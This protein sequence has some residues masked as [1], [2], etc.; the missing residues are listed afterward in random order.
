MVCLSEV[1]KEF[2]PILTFF[3][4]E[5][6]QSLNQLILTPMKSLFPKFIKRFQIFPQKGANIA[7]RFNYAFSSAFKKLNLDSVLIIGADTPHIQPKLIEESIDILQ[8]QTNTAVLGPSQNGGFYLLGHKQ[9]NIPHIGNIINSDNELVN[10][11][12]LLSAMN[13]VVHIL[14]EVTDVD[15]FENL[16]TIRAIIQLLVKSSSKELNYC[17]PAYTHEM[18]NKL[19][20]SI[21]KTS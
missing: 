11:M 8:A 10:A 9:P 3:P 12:D 7:Q 14:P 20:E 21:W 18:L 4:E 2:L 15:T 13:K 17:Y 5:N 1:Q 19:E 6:Q 16:K